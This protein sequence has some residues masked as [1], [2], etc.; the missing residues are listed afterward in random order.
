MLHV[1]IKNVM[2]VLRELFSKERR[3]E[4]MRELF[5]KTNRTRL[6]I[7]GSMMLIAFAAGT[8]W[9]NFV[10]KKKVAVSATDTLKNRARSFGLVEPLMHYYSQK[11]FIEAMSKCID[12]LNFEYDNEQEIPKAIIIGM[13]MMESDNGTS[14]FALEG[15]ALFGVRTWDPNVPHIKAYRSLDS[16]WGIKKYPTKC[17]SVRDMIHILNTKNVHRE[18]QRERAVQRIIGMKNVYRLAGS[19]NSWAT[20]PEYSEQLKAVIRDNGLDKLN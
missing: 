20:N 9:P 18:F 19:I 1:K 10:V 14:R 5:S 15:N 6:Y 8:F 17:A 11:T 16:K 4:W 7:I 3:T 2:R 13:A 12:Y